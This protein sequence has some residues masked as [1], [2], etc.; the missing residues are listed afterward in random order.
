M[1]AVQTPILFRPARSEAELEK[2]LRLRYHVYSD[3]PI[4]SRFLTRNEL[5][6][7]MDA[8]DVNAHHLGL[9]SEDGPIG[10]ARLVTLSRGPQADWIESIG[11]RHDEL[12]APSFASPDA[13]LPAMSYTNEI[14]PALGAFVG[15][16]NHVA[17]A[18]RFSLVPDQRSHG[19]AHFLTHAIITYWMLNGFDTAVVFC[20]VSHT[21]MWKSVGFLLAPGTSEFP[22]NGIRFNV[23]VVRRDWIPI[24]TQEIAYGLADQ[25]QR[26][27][28]LLA[29]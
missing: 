23:L 11:R 9:F 14:A 4:M 3:H 5:G 22:Y 24:E 25:F 7:D 28:Q 16:D 21:R 2:L 29:A 6:I 18:S 27:G 15:R 17:E 8:Y 12:L 10:S 20:R 1:S 13:P 19:L 26:H